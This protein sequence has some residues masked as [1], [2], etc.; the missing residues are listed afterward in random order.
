MELFIFYLGKMKSK[1]RIRN[2]KQSRFII[3][4]AKAL[5]RPVPF[6]IMLNSGNIIAIES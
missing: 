2:G 3:N 1:W 6:A 5:Q 4:K